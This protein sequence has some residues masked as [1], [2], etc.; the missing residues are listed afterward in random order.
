MKQCHT[1][2]HDRHKF[3]RLA[4]APFA[5]GEKELRTLWKELPEDQESRFIDFLTMQ[6]MAPLWDATAVCQNLPLLESSRSTLHQNRLANAALYLL[7]THSL[8]QIKGIL[9]TAEI[10]HVIIKGCHTRELYFPEAN[11]RPAIDIDILI[12]PE[13]KLKTI[14]TFQSDGYK[15]IAAAE[16][17]AQDCSLIK[18]D[19]AIDLHWDILRPGRTRHSMTH[20]LIAS[21]TKYRTHWGLDHG[22]TL[23]LMLVHP[24]FRKYSTSPRASL[25]RLIDLIQLLKIQPG[26]QA[27][28]KELLHRSGLET[29]G[30]T[31]L[32]WLEH[33]TGHHASMMS[34]IAPGRL[35]RRYL[36]HWLHNDY[37]SRLPPTVTQLGFTL[38]AHDTLKDAFRAGRLARYYR[39]N[40]EQHLTDL[41]QE[42]EKTPNKSGF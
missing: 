37:A 23:Y 2:M 27:K 15:F 35:R 26:S 40:G 36:H 33:L 8:Q 39:T 25:V 42:L 32:A 19:T 18:G 22:A 5:A 28:A 11:L 38:A 10:P 29:A 20:T 13:H 41:Q 16:N 21:R 3:H 34:T 17:V 14:R 4:L 1:L 9:D 12:A 30:W 31:T 6:G 7:Q 24:V